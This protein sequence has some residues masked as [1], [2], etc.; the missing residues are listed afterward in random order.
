MR[1]DLK[2]VFQ[3]DGFEKRFETQVD[4]SKLEIRGG[5]PLATPV[6]IEGQ[7]RNQNMVVNLQYR[8]RAAFVTFCDRCL[9]ETL[10][11][12]DYS[13]SHILA[14]S[15]TEDETGEMITVYD[16][17]LDL[18]ELAREDV[19]LQIPSKMLCSE[20]CAGLCPK[21]GQNL[22]HKRCGCETREI[23]P[24]WTKLLIQNS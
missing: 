15:D 1:I 22:N 2:D 9:D 13:F 17:R 23:D 5:F 21:C 18:E 6:M 16:F 12:I 20:D 14:A 19:L 7:A 24:R 11:E 10:Q 3:S 4:L 8:V